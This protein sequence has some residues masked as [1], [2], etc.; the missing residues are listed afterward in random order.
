MLWGGGGRGQV[1][2]APAVFFLDVERVD[3]HFLNYVI[4]SIKNASFNIHIS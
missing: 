4:K 3:Q 2:H 1:S